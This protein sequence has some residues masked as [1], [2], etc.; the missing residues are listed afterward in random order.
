MKQIDDPQPTCLNAFAANGIICGGATVRIDGSWRCT[1]GGPPREVDT[2]P[3]VNAA[4][5]W[6]R[7][8]GAAT[9]QEYSLR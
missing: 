9:I 3:T 4:R 8:R 7:E 6:L 1:W 2:V 5:Q